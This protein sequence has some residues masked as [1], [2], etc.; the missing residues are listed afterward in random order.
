MTKL[1][2]IFVVAVLSIIFALT[3]TASSATP[4]TS[5]DST[6]IST[7]VNNTT[8]ENAQGDSVVVDQNLLLQYGPGGGIALAVLAGILMIVK[9]YNEGRKI[10]VETYKKRYDDLRVAT[11]IELTKKQTQLE[12]T[13]AKVVVLGDSL[14]VLREALESRKAH[15]T[16]ERL[17][18]EARHRAQIEEI[19]D[20]LVKEINHRHLVERILAE[21]GIELPRETE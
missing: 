9:T 10:D 21:N 14:D 12:I 20:I 3:C 19:H 7:I 4:L 13:E 2:R 1:K 8:T 17:A 6:P 16:E 18:G 11:D 15:Y 5:T